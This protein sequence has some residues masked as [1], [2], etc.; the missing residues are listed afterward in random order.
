LAADPTLT[1]C[2][3]FGRKTL[4]GQM[5][6]PAQCGLRRLR[7]RQRGD[8]DVAVAAQVDDPDTLDAALVAA[9]AR[10][11]ARH[12]LKADGALDAATYAALTT[13]IARRV[14]Q[15][16]LTLERWRWLPAF[17]APPIIVNI[18]EFRLFAFNTKDDRAASILQMP[19]IVGQAYRDKQTPVFVGDLKWVVFRPYWDIPRSIV[20]REM[21]PKLRAHA[22]YAQRNHLEIVDGEGDDGKDVGADRGGNCSACR[23]DGA[24]AS[25]A[26]R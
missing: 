26:G 6:T 13:P 10:F 3:N 4:H 21:L 17:R 25:A 2:R 7:S 23:R 12:G 15:I 16:E 8:L 22:D 9:L 24:T 11:Q 14:R 20:L 1:N 18:P 19:V 5:P